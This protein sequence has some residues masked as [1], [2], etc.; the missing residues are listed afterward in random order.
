MSQQSILNK[1]AIEFRTIPN[2]IDKSVFN[3]GCKI[4]ARTEIGLC[5]K[6]KIIL[7]AGVSA[8]KNHAKGWNN[9]LNLINYTK[10]KKNF[11][12]TVILILG[13]SIKDKIYGNITLKSINW[14]SSEKELVNY[15]RASDLYL[16]LANAENFSLS[17]LEAMH[18]GIPVVASNVGGIPEQI[19]H[20]K[21]GFI[22]DSHDSAK[23]A[24]IIKRIL[25]EDVLHSTLS[26]NAHTHA[27][28]YY[29]Q[30]KMTNSYLA[31]FENV[32]KSAKD[33]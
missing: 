29:E 3:H 23:V 1:G 20:A 14:V 33:Y 15:Y 21:T 16:H 17:I 7:F 30:N 4:R 31:W 24:Q 2:G 28:K 5:Q 27:L 9:L 10:N 26:T 19:I 8:S 22:V 12:E 25:T 18:C 6:K 11:P 13:D 32:L